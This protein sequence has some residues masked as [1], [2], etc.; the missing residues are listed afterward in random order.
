MTNEFTY[1]RKYII[2]KKDYLNISDINPKGHVKIEIKGTK[3]NISINV[4]NCEIEKDYTINLLKDKNG[5]VMEF[6][7]GR[8]ITDDK[9]RGRVNIPINIRDLESQGFSIEEI[10][11]ILI[12]KDKY[13]LLGGYIDNDTGTIDRFVKKLILEEKDREAPKEYNKIQET[14]IEEPKLFEEVEIEVSKEENIVEEIEDLTELEPELSLQLEPEVDLEPEPE[15][16]LGEQSELNFEGPPIF[17]TEEPQDLDTIID[18]RV[19][20]SDDPSEHKFQYEE[21]HET[22]NHQSLEYIRRLNHRN[23]MTN[24]ILNI[25]RFFPYVQPFKLNLHGY[26]WWQIEDDGT[27]SYQGFLP[28]FNYLMSTNYKYPF[29]NNST[30]CF[31]QIKQ[32][33]HYLFGMYK[34]DGETKYYI[35]GVPGRFISE[36]H[37]FK[38]VT[39]FNTWYESM[40]NM[41]YW[42]LYI[43]PMTGKIIYPLNPMTPA[44]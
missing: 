18:E 25:L 12:R 27:D 10:N 38:G 41:G 26:S 30:T 19:E 24:Y 4:E 3:G 17:H 7:L 34:E 22:E 40:D 20:I 21:E 39:G 31:N 2:L 43:D 15:L 28:Y 9:G 37:P 13:I 8:L 36:E 1:L 29:L 44:Y 6:S 16:E 35:Y 23:Q 5:H 42:I 14:T 32:Y 33:G 11:A